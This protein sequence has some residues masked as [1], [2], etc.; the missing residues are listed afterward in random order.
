MTRTAV[1]D[2]ITVQN[3]AVSTL[4]TVV[5]IVLIVAVIIV[6]SATITLSE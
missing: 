1:G 5:V 4:Y 3:I 6:L 2:K